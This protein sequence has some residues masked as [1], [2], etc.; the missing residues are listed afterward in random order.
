MIIIVN[1]CFITF[2]VLLKIALQTLL[3]LLLGYF[4]IIRKFV[5]MN[6]TYINISF[7]IYNM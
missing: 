6:F 7:T 1:E 3:L 5:Y 4:N 2:P